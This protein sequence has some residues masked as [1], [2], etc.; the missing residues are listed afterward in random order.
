[1]HGLDIDKF[2]KV[3]PKV[4]TGQDTW[5]PEDEQISEMLQKTKKDKCVYVVFRLLIE[6]S[7]R[8]SEALRLVEIYKLE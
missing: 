8:L 2:R 7:I 3:I 1:M 6:S 5:T 4:R